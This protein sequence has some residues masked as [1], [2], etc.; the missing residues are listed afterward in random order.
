MMESFFKT[1]KHE[2][3]NLCQYETYQ[4]VVTR[5]PYFIEDVYND[6]RLHSALGYRPPH[7]FEEALLNQENS[8]THCQ[9]LLTYLSNHRGAV[10]FFW[11]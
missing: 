9:A 6:K 10:Q 1:L 5:L 11:G 3:V 8:E 4:N 2:E 7:E